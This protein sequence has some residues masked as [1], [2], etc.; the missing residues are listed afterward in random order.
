MLTFWC[1]TIA[2]AAT[3]LTGHSLLAGLVAGLAAVAARHVL[4][5]A[6]GLAGARRRSPRSSANSPSCLAPNAEWPSCVHV[7]TKPAS[8]E[9]IPTPAGPPSSST[10]GGDR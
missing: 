3:L 7:T 1:F 5:R 2:G 8:G 9:Y 6:A 10:A 4:P